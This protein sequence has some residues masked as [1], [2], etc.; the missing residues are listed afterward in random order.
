L[1][2]SNLNGATMMARMMMRREEEMEE[3]ARGSSV[4]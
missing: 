2:T 1:R 4:S 3:E